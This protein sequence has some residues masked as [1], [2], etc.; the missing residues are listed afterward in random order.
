MMAQWEGVRAHFLAGW[1]KR[2]FFLTAGLLCSA[3][4][5]AESFD[6][7]MKTGILQ[8]IRECNV[9]CTRQ[10]EYEVRL[11]G[12]L[13]PSVVVADNGSDSE[14]FVVDENV[15]HLSGLVRHSPT[16]VL[17]YG[18]TLELGINAS[19]P[20]SVEF[21]QEENDGVQINERKI[22]MFI[23]HRK[24]GKFSLG[25]GDAASNQSSESDL[26]GVYP[27]MYSSV[28][29]WG[30]SLTF[31]TNG[32]ALGT[33]FQG[34]DGL[35]RLGRLRYDS[36]VWKNWTFAAALI[37]NQRYDM[38]L[39][40]SRQFRG[41]RSK[42]ALSWVDR[43]RGVYQYTG[44]ASVLFDNGF[45]LTIAAGGQDREG[46]EP[47]LYYGKLAKTFDWFEWGKTLFS[48][49]YGYNGDVS[50]LDQEG[51]A[52]G[53]LVAQNYAPFASQFYLGVRVFEL[54]QPGVSYDPVLL[55]SGGVRV[56][57]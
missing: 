44:S 3:G 42:A 6:P 48:F 20:G 33:V 21:D 50:V 35:G 29:A 53:A 46:R 1:K 8:V 55:A 56:S 24:W 23:R 15:L 34:Y 40:F 57:F 45:S 5:L 54:D 13:N 19:G 49:D 14:L 41:F 37:N 17:E 22:E 26:S 51:R 52:Y 7:E 16:N 4:V 43:S 18:W 31:G 25:Q 36:P 9:V 32:P 27:I 12:L 38:A 47:F 28:A 30:S 2:V 39:K 11:L 10:P